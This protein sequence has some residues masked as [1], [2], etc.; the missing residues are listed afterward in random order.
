MRDGRLNVGGISTLGREIRSL[1]VAALF[2]R[3]RRE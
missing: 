3:Q 2:D 1:A